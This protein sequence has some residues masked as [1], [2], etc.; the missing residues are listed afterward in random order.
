MNEALK[1]VKQGLAWLKKDYP[2][3]LWHRKARVAE[4]L[5][6]TLSP[7]KGQSALRILF[8]YYPEQDSL[9]CFYEF[10]RVTKKGTIR[11]KYSFMNALTG[12]PLPGIAEEDTKRLKDAFAF[13]LVEQ[14]IR[15]KT[16]VLTQADAF[17]QVIQSNIQPLIQAANNLKGTVNPE[18]KISRG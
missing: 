14:K 12:G 5:A 17:L 15:S 18:K 6:L 7:Q 8:Q 16:N 2:L 10:I 13:E 11:E 1:A 3:K 4:E 9:S